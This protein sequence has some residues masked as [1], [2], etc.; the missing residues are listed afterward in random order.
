MPPDESGNSRGATL[1]NSKRLFLLAGI[2]RANKL[3]QRIN[4]LIAKLI[5]EALHH[6][7]F[8]AV[9]DGVLEFRIFLGCLPFRVG[10][11]RGMNGGKSLAVRSVAHG[12]L[13][14]EKIPGVVRRF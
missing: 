11:I 7:I 10:K 9:L 4:L 12:T 14:F 3:H 8:P 13:G 5:A 6:G 2:E 1:E